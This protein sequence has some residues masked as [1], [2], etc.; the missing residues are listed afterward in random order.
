[1]QS[2]SNA[3][4]AR[5]LNEFA[6]L[7]MATLIKRDWH[8]IPALY[9]AISSAFAAID[10]F[11]AECGLA[12]NRTEGIYTSPACSSDARFGEFASRLE[13]FAVAF[14]REAEG[15]AASAGL[16]H[17][18]TA[19]QSFTSDAGLISYLRTMESEA[20]EGIRL[21][22]HAALIVHAQATGEKGVFVDIKV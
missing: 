2:T 21:L 17:K 18:T 12:R 4:L 15:L 19:V 9:A 3:I 1:M 8:N 20:R 22:R 7:V 11:R 6:S 16:S 10:D 14:Q 5:L 13:P